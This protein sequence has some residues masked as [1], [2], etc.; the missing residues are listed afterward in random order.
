MRYKAILFDL[1]G[2]LLDSVSAILLA[3]ELIFKEMDSE[4]D[5]PLIRSLIGI[6]LEVQADILMKGREK[7]Y[8]TGYRR[9]YWQHQNKSID[10][11]PGTS[12]MLDELKNRGYLTGVVTSKAGIEVLKVLD[13]TGIADKFDLIISA[14][15]VE[16]PK[17][18][19]E[20]LLKAI[21]ALNVSADE[22]LYVGDSF[23]DADS[24]IAA[25]IKPVGVSWG[26]RTKEDMASK[27]NEAVF[28]TWQDFLDWLD[29]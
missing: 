16:N 6:P 19:P 27:C 22:A 10:L 24:A 25:N 8:I 14:D 13:S 21:E 3:N 20:P 7:E 9:L 1:D 28:D 5:E 17:P 11:F 12:Q 4:Y 26:A 15:D 23:F 18:H 2:T 29:S